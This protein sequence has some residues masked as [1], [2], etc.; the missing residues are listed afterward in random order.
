ML[1]MRNGSILHD[2]LPDFPRRRVSEAIQSPQVVARVF[3]GLRGHRVLLVLVWQAE[4]CAEMY[5]KPGTF[6]NCGA[7]H[8]Q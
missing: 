5:G 7:N 6:Q 1:R 4:S 2:E 3:L 8:T